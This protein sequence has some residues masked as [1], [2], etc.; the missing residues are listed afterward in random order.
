MSYSTRDV[1]LILSGEE[2]LGTGML[3]APRRILTVY[4]V[5]FDEHG[6][7]KPN[8]QV[9]LHGETRAES[10]VVSWAGSLEL[11]VAVLEADIARQPPVH[12]LLGLSPDDIA[13]DAAW[14]A[15]GYPAVRDTQPSTR[16]EQVRGKAGSFVRG[17]E[18][19]NLDV[20]AAPEK[21]H[22][23]SGG[24]VIIRDRIVGVIRAVPSNWGGKRLEATPVCIF[25]ANPEFRQALGIAKEDEILDERIQRM[26]DEVA[27][28]LVD[29]PDLVTALV[30]RLKLQS[31][32]GH[33]AL[34]V[35]RTLVRQRKAADIAGVFNQVDAD[36]AKNKQVQD[37]RAVACKI[38]WR[39]L[40]FATDWQKLVTAA[41]RDFPDKFTAA[42]N[43]LELPLRTETIA[44]LV[45]A[46]IDDRSCQYTLPGPGKM[47]VGAAV[48]RIPAA[49]RAAFID[50]DGS[51]LAECIVHDLATRFMVD[52]YKHYSEM[53]EAVEGLLQYH[54][55][56]AP[57]DE[58][59]PY[60]LLFVNEDGNDDNLY[61]LARNKLKS[62][63]PSLRLVRLT[64][65]DVYHETILAKHI[66]AILRRS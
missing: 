62:E 38:L 65:T 20:D 57:E 40:P 12:P 24:A 8:L 18:R 47:P 44:E 45:L 52:H 30:K 22:G 21:F 54:A 64:G 16:L 60:Y 41:L 2:W 43:F 34:D 56:F 61:A 28:I 11:D 36:L 49:A 37:N 9:R 33:S 48:V 14:E 7:K 39:I 15:H 58:L 26:I 23:L 50:V 53:R 66:D 27:A 35:A 4:H 3:V 5:V 1:A 19:L 10:A 63:L 42:S 32:P 51:R 6:Q 31:A 29:W 46:G 13:T 25:L 59:L 17:N 55:K